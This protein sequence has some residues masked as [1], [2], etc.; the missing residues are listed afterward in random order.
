MTKEC[1]GCQLVERVA[2][3]AGR[4]LLLCHR[5]SDSAYAE[6]ANPNGC[7]PTAKYWAA[8]TGVPLGSATAFS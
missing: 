8:R 2:Q 1:V 6:R 3:G 5:T 4:A 7:G